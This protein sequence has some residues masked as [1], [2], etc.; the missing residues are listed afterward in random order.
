MT[1]IDARNLPREALEHVR[2]QA[3]VLREQGY[4]WR[5][6]RRCAACTREP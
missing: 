2:R 5:T 1:K 4:T 3:F 6:S